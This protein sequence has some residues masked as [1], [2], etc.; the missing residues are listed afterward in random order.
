M[1]KRLIILLL[2]FP[3]TTLGEDHFTEISKG[4]CFEYVQTIPNKKLKWVVG[5]VEGLDL[6][7]WDLYGTLYG[8]TSHQSKKPFVTFHF[9]TSYKNRFKYNKIEC[10]SGLPSKKSNISPQI[11]SQITIPI[12][13]VYFLNL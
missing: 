3:L 5:R 10:P 12:K 7:S 4:D 11:Q 2:S 8:K 9:V 13:L 6:G 1:N